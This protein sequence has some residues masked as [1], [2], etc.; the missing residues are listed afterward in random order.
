VHR[1]NGTGWTV[2]QISSQALTCIWGLADDN[3][4]TA[5]DE[6]IVH[7]WDGNAWAA[8]SSPLGDVIFSIRGTSS[9]N[10]YAC[11]ANGLFWHFSSGTWTPIDLPTNQRLLGLLTRDASDVLVCGAGGTL[12]RGA[13][14][15]WND[16]SQPGHNFHALVEFRKEIYLAGGGEGIFR[17]DGISVT[18][19]KDTI[20]S[21]RLAPNDNYIASAGDTVAARFDGTAWFG[22]RYH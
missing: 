18:N 1:Y 9:D 19:V 5:G 3:V 13:G 16:R 4:Y 6:G 11:G 14:S 12:F 10:L 22:V 2:W 17:F 15:I 8:I 20:T 21:Y 7:R